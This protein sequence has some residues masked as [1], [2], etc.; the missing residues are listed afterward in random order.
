MNSVFRR[1]LTLSAPLALL[2]ASAAHADFN[3][4][5]G[6]QCGGS[7]FAT[8]A[9]VSLTWDAATQKATLTITNLGNADAVFKAVG[10]TNLP[11]GYQWDIATSTLNGWGTP[12]PN[13]LGGDGIPGA[14][15]QVN[16]PKDNVTHDKGI[17]VG[18]SLTFVFDFHGLTTQQIAQVGV[19]VHA[20]SGP[21]GCSTK[22]AFNSSGAITNSPTGGYSG[23]GASTVPEPATIGLVTTG[24]VGLG[25]AGFL[26]R[27]KH[28]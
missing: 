15:A 17:D 3:T 20:I 1:A 26:R 16:A 7:N 9:A 23:C 4:G 10:L 12:P 18:E 2:T 5:A 8:C 25:G 24:L 28:A 14:V 21:A 27:R 22:V 6:G 19:V 11:A 13:D